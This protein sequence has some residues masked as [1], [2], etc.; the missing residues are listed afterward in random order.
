[1]GIAHRI[2][3]TAIYLPNIF[4]IF[5]TKI[6]KCRYKYTIHIHPIVVGIY[7]DNKYLQIRP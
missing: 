3:G 7:N 5:T 4:I 6:K 2:N 1:M